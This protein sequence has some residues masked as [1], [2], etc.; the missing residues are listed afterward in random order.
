MTKVIVSQRVLSIKDCD[1]ILLLDDG[2][3]LALGSHEQLMKSSEA[4]QELVETQLGG[5]DFDG[6]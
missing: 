6:E 1:Y 4:Y 2:K 3:V 5:G